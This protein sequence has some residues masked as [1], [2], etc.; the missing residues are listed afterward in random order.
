MAFVIGFFHLVSCFPGSSVRACVTL[1]PC[2]Q[3]GGVL[4]CG[5]SI[6]LCV[7]QVGHLFFP[8]L[9]IMTSGAICR[10][11]TLTR[12]HQFLFSRV[13]SITRSCDKFHESSF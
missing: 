10:V 6:C 4:V 12:G 3:L 13:Y 1:M 7:F 8:T 11:T 2:K 5:C 9:A